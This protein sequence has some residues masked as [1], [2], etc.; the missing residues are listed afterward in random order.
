[1]MKHYFES[2]FNEDLSNVSSFTTP[3]DRDW[4]TM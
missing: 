1:M 4:E 2:L 3:L